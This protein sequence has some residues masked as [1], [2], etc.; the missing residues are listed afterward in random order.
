LYAIEVDIFKKC[1]SALVGAEIRISDDG[2][3]VALEGSIGI[4]GHRIP[5]GSPKL[6]NWRSYLSVLKGY[7]KVTDVMMQTWPEAIA[8]L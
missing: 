1:T 7:S 6:R 4:P 5:R 2:L 3:V 8:M